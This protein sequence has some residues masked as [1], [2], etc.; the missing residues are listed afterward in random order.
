MER[1]LLPLSPLLPVRPDWPAMAVE[2][3]RAYVNYDVVCTQVKQ[4]T[5][6]GHDFW[7][8]KERVDIASGT[9]LSWNDEPELYGRLLARE[10]I[11]REY[12]QQQRKP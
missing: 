11:L 5:A 3:A 2:L 1:S 6:N 8:A 9:V 4:G 10:Q 7:Q 12:E